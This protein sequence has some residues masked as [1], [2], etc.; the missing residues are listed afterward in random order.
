MQVESW[1]SGRLQVASLMELKVDADKAKTSL[2][3]YQI[4]ITNYS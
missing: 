2:V 1:M 4:V 3:S